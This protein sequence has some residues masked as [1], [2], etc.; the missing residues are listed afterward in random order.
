MHRWSF[1][2]LG[3]LVGLLVVPCVVYAYL[4]YGRPPVAVSDGAFPMEKTIV[5]AA[6]HRRIASE[7]KQPSF[8]ATAESDLAGAKVYKEQCAFCHG[9]PKQK[10]AIGATMYPSAPQLW[11]AHRGGVVGVSDDPVGETYW[12]VRNG[13]RLTGMPSYEHLLSEQQLWQ[14][15]LL[16]SRADKPLTNEVQVALG[17]R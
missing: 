3:F 13:I 12:R 8:E 5:R 17:I 6:L 9:I 14:V 2:G 4:Y 15:S 16:L 1:V 10:S 7:M 11:Q